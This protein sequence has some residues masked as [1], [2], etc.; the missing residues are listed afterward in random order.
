[1]THEIVED[2]I[3]EYLTVVND[4]GDEV[5]A[6]C[7]FHVNTD[8]PAFYI[9]KRT[10][11]WTC[12][13]PACGQRG[14]FK[15]LVQ[16]LAGDAGVR[17]IPKEPTDDEIL[18][19]LYSVDKVDDQV[20]EVAMERVGINYGDDEDLKHLSTLLDRGFH[21]EVLRQFEVGYSAR[22]RRVVI[23]T[24]DEHYKIVG[25][26]GRAIGSEQIPR[27]LYSA[28][29]PRK[30]CMFNLQRAKQ[31]RSV[32]VTE[33]SL[34]AI[35]VHQ[36]GFPN[37]VATLGASVPKGHGVLL[38]KYFDEVILFMD[39]DDAG[40]SAQCDIIDMCG[41][42]LDAYVVVYGSGAKDP[43]DMSDD[44]IRATLTNKISYL[45]YLYNQYQ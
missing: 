10:G 32:I 39:N 19:F 14:N 37:V 45:D 18:A 28:G 30:T 41:G 16:R 24:R 27:Y 29:F 44:Q 26:I 3:R 21:Q 31:F 7:P 13:N 6:Y 25:F 12:F 22:Q 17:W 15:T 34:D 23:P 1:M 4:S 38:Q 20:L 9:N 2:F 35:K 43:G 5:A 33:G 42:R 36:A 8:S 40:R 11:L